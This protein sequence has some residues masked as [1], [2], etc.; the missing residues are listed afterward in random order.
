MSALLLRVVTSL[1]AVFIFFS[2]G[3]QPNP[4]WEHYKGGIHLVLQVESKG[5]PSVDT[6]NTTR[7]AENI[8]ERIEQFGIKRRI[9]KVQGERQIVIQL[10]PC[11]NPDRAVDLISKPCILEFKLVDDEFSLQRALAGDIPIGDVILYQRERDPKTG[12][13]RKI[14]YLIKDKTL[15]TGDALKDARVQFD[16]HNI[17]YIAISLNPAGAREFDRITADNV[18]K[19][20]AIILDDNIYTAP[21]IKQ[22]ISGGEAVIESHFS[23]EEAKDLTNVLRAGGFPTPVKVSEHRPL[24]REIWLGDDN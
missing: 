10:P 2:I 4:K 20:L 9:I 21:I 15:M 8:E 16:L 11:K 1:F 7:I 13:V 17:P 3:C 24:S 5:N 19:R 14:P 12:T 23:L 6:E 18:G 22:R